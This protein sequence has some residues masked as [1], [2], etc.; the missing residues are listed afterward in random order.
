M[1]AAPQAPTGMSR[2]LGLRREMLILLPVATLALVVVST[3]TLFAYRSGLAALLEERRAEA[4]RIARDAAV[5][6]AARGTAGLDLGRLA[7][8]ARG[9]A[10]LDEA[11]RPLERVGDVPGEN[12]LAPLAGEKLSGPVG[13]GP[14]DADDAV[15]GFA[16]LG[17]PGARQIVRVDL[18]TPVL[19]AQRRSALLF[20]WVLIGL[21]LGLALLVLIFLRTVLQPYAVMLARARESGAG[22][23]GEDEVAFL[24]E[25]FERALAALVRPAP[26][27]GDEIAALERALGPNLESGLLLLDREGSLLAVN[28]VGTALLGLDNPPA[29]T[30]LERLLGGQPELRQ[31]LAEAVATG[32]VERRRECAITV[33]GAPCVVGLTVHPLRRDDGGVRG[34]LVLFADLTEARQREEEHRLAESLARIGELAAGIAHELRNS[35][36]TLRGY[37]TLIERR[38]DEETIH[39]YLGEIRRETD[40]LQRVLED[41][42]AFARP[43]SVRLEEVD[44]ERLVRRAA[45]DPAL[46]GAAVEVEAPVGARLLIKGDPQLLERALRNLLKNAAQAQQLAGVATPIAVRLARTGAELEVAVEDRGPGVPSEIRDRMFHPFVSGSAEGVGLGLA[47]SHRIVDLHGGRIVLEDRPGGGTRATVVLPPATP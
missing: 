35:L 46:G 18:R 26:Q 24:L 11:G 43:G 31:I 4:A 12:L 1:S 40:H 8:Q 2:R 9:I 38:P 23:E 3:V 42:L 7:P 19:A 33:A 34:Y 27:Q 45:A 29:G 41:F 22:A 20:G 5:E 36:A 30:P 15:S 13:A 10:L 44:L 16:P 47:L 39:D 28:P 37:L 21:N 32:H 17:R 6:I 14:L 25:T